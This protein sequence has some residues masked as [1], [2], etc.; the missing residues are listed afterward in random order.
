MIL[1][2]ERSNIFTGDMFQQS[3][4]DAQQ[5]N[6]SSIHCKYIIF[7][8]TSF[9]F[10]TYVCILFEKHIVAPQTFESHRLEWNQSHPT[11]SHAS[12][13]HKYVLN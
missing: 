3:V 9:Y 12:Y 1:Y 11:I 6:I 13:I 8:K 7:N 10:I 4:L 2:L 5:I